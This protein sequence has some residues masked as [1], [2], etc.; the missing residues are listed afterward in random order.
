MAYR[1]WMQ[2]TTFMQ[3]RDDAKPSASSNPRRVAIPLLPKLKKELERMESMKVISNVDELTGVHR[4]LW[5]L[6][7]TGKFEFT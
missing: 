5:Y 3:L 7:L 6:R 2:N 4:W 1:N